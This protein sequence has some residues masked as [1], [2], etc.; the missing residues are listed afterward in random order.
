[1]YICV[2]LNLCIRLCVWQSET[3]NLLKRAFFQ[4]SCHR[5]LVRKNRLTRGENP[6]RGAL[7]KARHEILGPG[8]H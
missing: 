1:M 5:S 4:K 7:L 8:R 3:L 6:A 2:L